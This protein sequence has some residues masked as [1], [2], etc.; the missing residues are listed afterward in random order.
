MKASELWWATILFMAGQ[1]LMG[2]GDG[3]TPSAWCPDRCDCRWK[4]GKETVE[5]VNASLASV[6]AKI[7]KDTQVLDLS[8]NYLPRLEQG[9]FLDKA[10]LPNLQ[11]VYLA[12]CSISEVENHAFRYVWKSFDIPIKVNFVIPEWHQKCTCSKRSTLGASVRWLDTDDSL[13]PK[14]AGPIC[15][16][17]SFHLLLLLARF[18]WNAA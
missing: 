2:A 12:Y 17:I 18:S 15:I 7:G 9:L 6:P 8:L 11:K 3:S 5:C 10:G 13:F 4:G 1:A 16:T 14:S